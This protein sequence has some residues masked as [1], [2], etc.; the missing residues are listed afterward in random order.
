[1][2]KVLSRLREPSTWAGISVL[3]LVF[4]LPEGT[5][6]ALGQVVGGVAALGAIYL[7]EKP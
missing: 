4:G 5:V 6:Q 3:G 2:G 1:M 7:G